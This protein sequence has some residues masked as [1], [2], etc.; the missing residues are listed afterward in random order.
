MKR[1]I[2]FGALATIALVLAT[3]SKAQAWGCCHAG[4]THVGYGGVQHYGS[5]TVTGRY[6]NTYSGA[7]YGSTSAYGG[8]HA[9]YGSSSYGGYHAYAGGYTGGYATG[10]YHYGSVGYGTTGYYRGW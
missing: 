2:L 7:H 10:G 4:Y 1:Q 9:G 5:T 6:G 8:Y 3:A